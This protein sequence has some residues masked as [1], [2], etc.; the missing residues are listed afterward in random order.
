MVSR[1]GLRFPAFFAEII[2]QSVDIDLLGRAE[3]GRLAQGRDFEVRRY[4]DD[5]VIFANSLETLDGLQR[6]L[7]ESLQLLNLHLNDSKTLTKHRPLQTRKSQ[8]IADATVGLNRFRDQI[9]AFD[10]DAQSTIPSAIRNPRALARTLVNDMK[11]ACTN[12]DAGYED[13]SPYIIGSISTTIENLIGSF[14]SAK[15][16]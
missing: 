16:I 13:I 3:R 1:L 2:L 14:N 8:I 6:G 5:Y 10:S 11:V 7:S 4:I 12:A 15:T 9:S